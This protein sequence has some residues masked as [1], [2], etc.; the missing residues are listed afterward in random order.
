MPT[1]PVLA[2][3]AGIALAGLA[4]RVPGRPW[5]RAAALAGLLLVVLAQPIAADLRTG[6]LLNREDTRMLARQFLL[7]ELPRK[8]RIVVEP[9]TPRGYFLKRVIK[10]FN[11]P[12]EELVAGG[13]PQRFILS[14]D[15]AR[16]DLYREAGYCTVVT[17]SAVRGRAEMD[18]VGPALA[19]YR[20]LERQSTKIFH[21][22]PYEEGA[23]APPFDFDQSTHL[24][25]PGVY[26]RP[27][28]EVDIYRLDDCVQGVGGRPVKV[29]PPRRALRPELLTQGTET[30]AA[31]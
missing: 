3:L 20:A 11:A 24:Y 18:R 23:K 22:D 7:A 29:A 8:A 19:Y 13:T 21:A 30:A 15:P 25:Y 12:P 16:L 28:P 4:A 1:Y 31:R 5:M 26:H 10:G 9:A 6:R 14:L 2:L 27:G 17:F